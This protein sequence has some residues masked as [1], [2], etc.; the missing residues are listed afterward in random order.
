MCGIDDK[1]SVF[2]DQGENWF[3]EKEREEEIEHRNK[4]QLSHI[5]EKSEQDEFD[6]E[7]NM[8]KG[9]QDG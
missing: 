8:Q 7:Q 6:L 5:K 9:E 2:K 1:D 3:D 4:N